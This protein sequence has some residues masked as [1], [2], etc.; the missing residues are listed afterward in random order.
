MVVQSY[1][2][3][4]NTMS[5]PP[6]VPPATPPVAITIIPLS[7]EAYAMQMDASLPSSVLSTDEEPKYIGQFSAEQEHAILDMIAQTFKKPEPPASSE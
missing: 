6:P 5:T 2:F 3:H 7:R 1:F 4:K